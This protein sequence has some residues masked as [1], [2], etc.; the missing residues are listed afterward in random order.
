MDHSASEKHQAKSAAIMRTQAN[1]ER[2][3]RAIGGF[4]P[5]FNG[6]TKSAPRCPNESRDRGDNCCSHVFGRPTCG[7]SRAEPLSRRRNCWHGEW[8]S[9]G[10]HE[11]RLSKG[12]VHSLRDGWKGQ[13]HRAT[14][15][16][17]V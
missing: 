15:R 8:P 9:V 13:L 6:P 3:L 11:R 12:D 10:A 14:S 5:F 1:G 4:G 7:G 17:T 2:G 16:Y